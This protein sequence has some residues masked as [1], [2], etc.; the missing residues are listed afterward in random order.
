MA[1]KRGFTA[2]EA[3]IAGTMD[4]SSGNATAAPAPRNSVRRESAR[5][6]MNIAMVYSR[7]ATRGATGAAAPRCRKESLCTTAW[8]NAARL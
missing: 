4:S 1:P 5:R 2:G 8:I 3:D 7:A 6:V